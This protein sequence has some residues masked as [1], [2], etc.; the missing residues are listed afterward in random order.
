MTVREFLTAEAAAGRT[1]EMVVLH[2]DQGQAAIPA[3]SVLDAKLQAAI[4]WDMEM[5]E[6][7]R[8]RVLIDKAKY[9]SRLSGEKGPFCS[10]AERLRNGEGEQ[11]GE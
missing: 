7:C 4:L 1:V 9:Q 8:M 5:E 10:Q 2:P 3:Y 6:L 11:E